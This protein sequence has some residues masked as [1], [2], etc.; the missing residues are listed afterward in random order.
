MDGKVIIGTELS[1]DEID[2]QI[3]LLYGKLEQLEN[4]Y[5]ALETEKPFEGQTN[6]LIKLGTEIQSTK[7]KIRGLVKAKNDL[8]KPPSD[9][10]NWIKNFGKETTKVARKVV[11]IGVAFL[12]IRSVYGFLQSSISTLSSYNEK[13]KTDVEYIRFALATTLQPVIE[14]LIQLAYQL[15]NAFGSIVKSITGVNI[16]ENAGIDK[17][18]RGLKGSVGAAKDLKK[19]LAGFDEMNVLQD[20]SSSGGASGGAGA[21]TPSVDLSQMKDSE[22]PKWLDEV[23]AG[24]LGIVGALSALNL[25]IEPLKAL[26]VGVIVAGISYSIA[27]LL[28]YL[29]EPTWNSFGKIIQGIGVALIGLSLIVGGLPVAIA[30]VIVLIIGTIMKYW[31][32][33]KAFLQKGIDWLFESID[34]VKDVF[35]KV[36][37][38]FYKTFVE[39]LQLVL[40]GFDEFFKGIRKIFDGIIELVAG[41]FTGNWK[42]AWEGVKKI[43]SGIFQSLTGIVA[44]VLGTIVGLAS[45]IGVVIGE[46]VVGTIKAVVNFALSTI[47][48]RINDFFRL[49]NGAIKW[50][51]KIPGVNIG[52]I[53]E[54]KFPRLAKGGIVNM[55][56][57]GVN[58]AGANIGERRPEGIIPLTDSQQMALLGE[59]IG[60]FITVNLAVTN[61]MNGRV[62]SRELQKINSENN[63][64]FNR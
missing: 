4:E 50:I 46:A 63:F 37:A 30:G 57:R 36:T 14:R 49:I 40:Y 10:M 21:T 29:K 56:G 15:L 43:F 18:Q 23:T 38:F 64:A 3:D 44:S 45:S 1:T 7:G 19:Q 9:I 20:T 35:G 32:E 13:I 25:G 24:V 59:A 2:R 41:V 54:V 6:E 27:G 52:K 55:P 62:I 8:D 34:S 26:G 31:D 5:E 47:E 53:K 11:A 51:N 17:F 39:S 12:G 33:I 61:S 42:K 16:F 58:Y 22:L 28:E 48:N 60:K